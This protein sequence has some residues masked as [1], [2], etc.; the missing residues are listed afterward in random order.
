MHEI[1]GAALTKYHKPG[2]LKQLKH[3]VSQFWRLPARYPNVCRALLHLK[4]GENYSL[5]LSGGLLAIFDIPSLEAGELPSL[6]S[7]SHN[8][9]PL[10][11]CLHTVVY[12]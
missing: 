12:L 8:I 10:F 1:P 5:P 6:P 7:L 2:D 3:I 4:A 9:L 11:L